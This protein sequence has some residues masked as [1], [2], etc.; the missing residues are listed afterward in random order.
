MISGGFL[1][2]RNYDLELRNL[3]PN[4]LFLLIVSRELSVVLIYFAG[5]ADKI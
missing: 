2:L 5:V 4:L 3:Y 1:H